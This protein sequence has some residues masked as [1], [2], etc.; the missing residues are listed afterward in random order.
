ML[1][2]TKCF[3]MRFTKDIAQGCHNIVHN[4]VSYYEYEMINVF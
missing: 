3:S 4:A 2:L 1:E